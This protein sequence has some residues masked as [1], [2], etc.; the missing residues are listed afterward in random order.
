[1]KY[2]IHKKKKRKKKKKN[3]VLTVYLSNS[4]KYKV[5]QFMLTFTYKLFKSSV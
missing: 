2:E 4:I 5:M 1:M 3:V